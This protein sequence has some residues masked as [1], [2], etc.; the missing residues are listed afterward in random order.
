MAPLE[1]AWQ[2]VTAF[3][4]SNTVVTGM[5]DLGEGYIRV[6][7]KNKPVG[8][9]RFNVSIMDVAS[10]N[11]TVLVQGFDESGT[12]QTFIFTAARYQMAVDSLGQ[13]TV[14][15]ELKPY[16]RAPIAPATPE[17]KGPTG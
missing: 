11:V 4:G 3:S 2:P 7:W 17:P 12:T 10:Q 15:V 16:V 6:T 13:W 14:K 5:F 1:G 9:D 8:S